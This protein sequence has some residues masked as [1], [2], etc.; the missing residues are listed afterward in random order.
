[1]SL[2]L[3]IIASSRTPAASLLLDTYPN[4]FGAYSLRKLRT[5]YTGAAIRVRRSSDNTETDIGFLNN[6]LDTSALL[7][8]C[9]FSSGYVSRVYTQQGHV[10]MIQATL[11]AQPLIVNVGVLQ[12]LGTKPCLVYDGTNSFMN[13]IGNYTGSNLSI[14]NVAKINDN[15]FTVNFG[16]NSVFLMFGFTSTFPADSITLLSRYKNNVITSTADATQ[17]TAVFGNNTYFVSSAYY[18]ATAFQGLGFFNQEGI[19]VN[20][21]WQESVFYQ[22]NQ[23]SNNTGINSNIN[24]Y[25]SIY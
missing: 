20:G 22:S 6:E 12:T 14:F 25:Y 3:G 11:A 4:A 10:D 17:V 23:L 18:G 9:G 2:N 15:Y 16:G 7:T 19:K 21:S 13:G 8:F 5:A 1:M 24:S